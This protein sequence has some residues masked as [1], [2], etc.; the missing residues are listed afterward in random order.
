MV[1][2]WISDIM[3]KKD[4]R[5]N[6]VEI[7]KKTGIPQTLSREKFINLSWHKFNNGGPLFHDAIGINAC[8]YVMSF[9]KKSHNYYEYRAF[10]SDP[11]YKPV[12]IKEE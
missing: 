7:L 9:L 1:E 4:F 10:M 5:H 6:L 12:A 8:R 3:R 2:N 11:L